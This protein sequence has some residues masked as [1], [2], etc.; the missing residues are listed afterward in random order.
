MTLAT[1]TKT[2][3]SR[4]FKM[5]RYGRISFSFDALLL[6]ASLAV[7]AT[8]LGA[9]GLEALTGAAL[10]AAIAARQAIR[11]DRVRAAL[12]G[13]FAG[14]FVGALCAGFFHTAIRAVI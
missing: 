7:C 9:G 2:T 1:M 8:L 5:R 3:A 12:G 13:A 10:G 11:G 14:L 6:A 4:R